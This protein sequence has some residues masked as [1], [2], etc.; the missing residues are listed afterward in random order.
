MSDTSEAILP[1]P[2]I[3]IDADRKPNDT[4]AESQVRI[5]ILPNPSDVVHA[6][7]TLRGKVKA[8]AQQTKDTK[9]FYTEGANPAV[10]TTEEESQS[11]I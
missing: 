4:E 11:K 7:D 8:L 10:K 6:P 1:E 9:A 2:S 5:P 3:V